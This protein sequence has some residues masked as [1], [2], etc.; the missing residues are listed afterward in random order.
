MRLVPLFFLA[1]VDRRLA[2]RLSPPPLSL[3]FP[4]FFS[5]NAE[6]R[7]DL[8]FSPGERRHAN[9]PPVFL[10]SPL[11]KENSSLSLHS[12]LDEKDLLSLPPF[13]LPS[14]SPS[15]R[16]GKE[17]ELSYSLFGKSRGL[18][19]LF[20]SSFP[21]PKWKWS[22][23]PPFVEGRENKRNGRGSP[24]SLFFPPPFSPPA[25]K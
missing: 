20:F 19:P 17:S 15:V 16:E 21:P 3:F 23:S 12:V 25:R 1:G 22:F 10:P 18:P 14:L 24:L 11:E 7:T 2:A 6:R 5:S 4:P 13:L 8:T 9:L